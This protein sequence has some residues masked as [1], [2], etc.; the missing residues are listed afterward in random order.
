MSVLSVTRDLTIWV[1]ASTS[2][3]TRGRHLY[4]RRPITDL[5]T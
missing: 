3:G 1:Q 2:H 5:V 4:R